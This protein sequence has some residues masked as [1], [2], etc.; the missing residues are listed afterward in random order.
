MRV[1][2]KEDDKYKYNV[3]DKAEMPE[4]YKASAREKIEKDCENAAQRHEITYE[5]W[6]AFYKKY[7]RSFFKERQWISREHPETLVHSN[8][9]LELGCGTGSTLIPII[10]ERI[11]G[12][13]DYLQ[14]MHGETI[15]PEDPQ[16]AEKSA[17]S[18][19]L[20]EEADAAKCR[21][22]FGVDYSRTAVGLLQE[23]V[24]KIKS[25][26]SHGD[27]TE[28]QSVVINGQ[29]IRSADIILLIYTLSAIHPSAHERIFGLIHR[30]LAEGGIVILKDYYEMDLTQLR[31]KEHQALEK[32]FYVRGDS[33]Y[34]YYFT[35]ERLE[36]LASGM[37]RVVKYAEETKLVLNRKKQKEMYR[38]FVEVKL[39]KLQK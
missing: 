5:P 11:S 33:T 7:S 10:K 1:L 28:M 20:M 12:K 39:E 17:E 35:R 16:S 6:D 36:A 37:F 22:I 32:N 30:S 26:F 27:I 29:E 15:S 31:F 24:P 4:A 3:W 19:I 38:C 14:K 21:N 34:V 23:R 25:Q 9:I 18:A 13:S 2:T 8:T